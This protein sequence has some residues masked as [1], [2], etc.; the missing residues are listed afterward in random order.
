MQKHEIS[1]C[2]CEQLGKTT[3]QK[4]NVLLEAF[5]YKP[6]LMDSQKVLTEPVVAMPLRDSE[7]FRKELSQEKDLHVTQPRKTSIVGSRHIKQ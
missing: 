5:T 7:G 4:L 1:L 2:D 3:D 6:R